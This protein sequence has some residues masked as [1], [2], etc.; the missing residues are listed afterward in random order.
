L[1][2]P[3]AKLPRQLFFA[4]RHERKRIADL[5][6]EF[7]QAPAETFP[8]TKRSSGTLYVVRFLHAFKCSSLGQITTVLQ[9]SPVVVSACV[10]TA[11]TLTEQLRRPLTSVARSVHHR[12]QLPSVSMGAQLHQKAMLRLL[13]STNYYS[14]DHCYVLHHLWLHANSLIKGASA[15]LQ[16]DTTSKFGPRQLHYFPFYATNR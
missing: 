10:R 9:L 1:L 4:W 5:S 6:I 15:S 3:E 12:H 14:T 8:T 11:Y 16:L 2:N 13:L 7:V